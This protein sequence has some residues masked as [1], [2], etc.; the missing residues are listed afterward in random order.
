[1]LVLHVCSLLVIDNRLQAARRRLTLGEVRRRQRLIVLRVGELVDLRE[2]FFGDESTLRVT[3]CRVVLHLGQQRALQRADQVAGRRGLAHATIAARQRRVLPLWRLAQPVAAEV[4][5]AAAQ[6]LVQRLGGARRNRRRNLL[7]ALAAAVG[8]RV[9]L[10]GARLRERLV[11]ADFGEAEVALLGRPLLQR[12]VEGGVLQRRQRLDFGVRPIG[13][14]GRRA[15]AI[16]GALAGAA[17]IGAC[18]GARRRVA[19]GC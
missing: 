4:G 15:A 12:V 14:A 3:I 1:M 8:E 2:E 5:G 16:V 19:G 11:G 10:L 17:R 6:R 13:Y 18:C 9:R 7:A